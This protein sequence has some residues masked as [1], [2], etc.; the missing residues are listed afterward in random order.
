M[1]A[2]P[3]AGWREVDVRVTKT[4]ADWAVE[5]VRIF[6]G[7]YAECE[8]VILVCDNRRLIRN[9]LDSCCAGSTSTIPRNTAV[10]KTSAKTNSV[11]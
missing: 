9:E 4:K 10:G 8:K 1:F 3:L 7:R 11:P 5:V 2:E 6:E